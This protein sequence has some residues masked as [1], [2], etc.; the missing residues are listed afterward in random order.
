MF[1]TT[2]R[3]GEAFFA[4]LLLDSDGAPITGATELVI[5]IMH[6]NAA[7]TST[8]LETGTASEWH[9]ATK[10]GAYYYAY[11][12]AADEAYGLIFAYADA[13]AITGAT[14]DVLIAGYEVSQRLA[15][16]DGAVST[17]ASAEALEIVSGYA[18][19]AQ[20]YSQGARDRFGSGITTSASTTLTAWLTAMAAAGAAVPT[21]LSSAGFVASTD[22]MQAVRDALAQLVWDYA[23][24]TLTSGGGASVQNIFEADPTDYDTD[25]DSFAARVL[26]I[27]AGTNKINAN[28]TYTGSVSPAGAVD[29]YQGT[30]YHADDG[31]AHTWAFASTINLSGATVTLDLAGEQ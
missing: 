20:T 29:I 17:R 30:D 31:T 24:R 13:D 16:L 19:N 3:G 25:A 8:N 12:V 6:R 18:L 23:S 5:Q 27:L 28:F 26:A 10:P 22:S 4:F 14:V 15:Y 11:D 9:A 7:G 1:G 2:V 21:A